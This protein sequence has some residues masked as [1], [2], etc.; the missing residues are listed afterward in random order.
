MCPAQPHLSDLDEHYGEGELPDQE[1]QL[2]HE[3][4]EVGLGRGGR[5]GAIPHENG[6]QDKKSDG[7]EEPSVD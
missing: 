7:E 1:D 2:L 4:D 6:Q 5:G 3:G